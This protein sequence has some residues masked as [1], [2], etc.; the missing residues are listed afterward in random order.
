VVLQLAAGPE[1][2][3]QILLNAGEAA[4]LASSLVRAAMRLRNRQIV[5]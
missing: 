1:A 4:E 3:L 5:N 2:A